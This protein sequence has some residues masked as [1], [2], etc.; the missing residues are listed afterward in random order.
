[1]M[2]RLAT[3]SNRLLC[4]GLRFCTTP[5][6]RLSSRFPGWSDYPPIAAHTVDSETDVTCHKRT[7]APQQKVPYSITSSVWASNVGEIV[8]PS[9]CAVFILIAT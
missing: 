1:M 5:R 7:H 4:D 2:Q 6:V 3:R 9:A 8:R